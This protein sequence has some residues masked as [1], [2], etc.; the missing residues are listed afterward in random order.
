MPTRRHADP[1]GPLLR[2]NVEVTEG[3]HHALLLA[4][5]QARGHYG[6]QAHRRLG[7]KVHDATLTAWFGERVSP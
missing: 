3:L 6:A 4:A 2:V 5:R 1:D 7:Y